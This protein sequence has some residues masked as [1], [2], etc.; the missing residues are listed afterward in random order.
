M[1]TLRFVVSF[2]VLLISGLL[3]DLSAKSSKS[4][5]SSG[6]PVHVKGYTK[7]DGTYVAP[8]Y[9]SAPDG[10]KSN[11][12]STKGNVNPYTGKAGT[13]KDDASAASPSG[14]SSVSTGEKAPTA[15]ATRL[16]SISLGTSKQNVEKALGA[17]KIKTAK[18]WVYVD[19][20]TVEFDEAGNVLRIASNQK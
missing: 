12:W 11:N 14:S 10:N 9:R 5:S 18:K 8:H 3:S 4:G 15:Q 16:Q 13:Q 6:K 1:K 20:G 7:K 2:A 17:P 19:E